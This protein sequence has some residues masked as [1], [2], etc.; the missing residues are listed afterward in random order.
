MEE[1]IPIVL[2]LCVAG[3][4]IL[5]PISS[6]MGSLLEAMARERQPQQQV[7]HGE[8]ARIRI[9]VEHV[10]KRVDLMEERLDFTERLLTNSRRPGS[11]PA[12]RL[13][14]L[15]RERESEFLQG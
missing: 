4:I 15:T 5:R 7:D 10:A 9:L 14:S 13:D 6:K 8:I 3:V 1:F 12:P 2:F 11:G